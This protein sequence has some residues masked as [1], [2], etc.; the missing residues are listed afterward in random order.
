[1][2]TCTNCGAT[3]RP[4]AKFCTTCGTRLNEMP[5]ANKGWETPPAT[6]D[7][8]SQQTTV[9]DAVQP[10]TESDDS[11]TISKNWQRS[12][13]SWGSA[14][15]AEPATPTSA[16]SSDDPA[17]RFISALDEEVQPAP[18][19]GAE[20]GAESNPEPASTWEA[21]APAFTPPPPSNWSYSSSEEPD[22]QEEADE[23]KD[24]D[25]AWEAPST[26]NQSSS[27]ESESQI[28]A[29]ADDG[30]STWSAPAT[31]G[32]VT[33]TDEPA[34]EDAADVD[35]AGFTDGG[36]EEVDYL[37]GDENIELAEEPTPELAPDEARGK[38]IALADELRRTIR[39]MGSG[40]E[41]DHG[42]AVMALT[43]A[44]LQI[45]D[46]SD[47]RGVLVDVKND[48]R[49]I[50]TLGSLAGKADR[51]DALLDEHKALADA[52]EEAIKELN[53]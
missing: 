8:D 17:S 40:G 33:T 38:A 12:A 37:S 14:Y 2:D 46:F 35:S 26:W 13:D 16:A 22:A 41:S 25:A 9:L 18:E 5:P 51:I 10:P 19:S 36:D 23:D 7:D 6:N 4:G 39:M 32:A 47:L 42:A 43:E 44:S 3:L 50:Q 15:A 53:G 34:S 49:D 20:T 29:N 48:P 45:G 24:K 21:S 1:M 52:I 11:T 31:W 27:G 30:N 28:E